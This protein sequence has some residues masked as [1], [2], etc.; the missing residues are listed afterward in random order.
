LR[1]FVP[2]EAG[3]FGSGLGQRGVSESDWMRL[4]HK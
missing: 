4:V 1:T 2:R 3:E